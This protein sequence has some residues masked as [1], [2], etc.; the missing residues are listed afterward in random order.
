MQSPRK[1]YCEW[2]GKVVSL[3]GWAGWQSS[4]THGLV[5]VDA[6]DLRLEELLVGLEPGGPGPSYEVTKAI[7]P[8][9]I[10]CVGLKVAGFSRTEM[11]EIL[12][13]SESWVTTTLKRPELQELLEEKALELV[14]SSV[15]DARQAVQHF[16]ME[17]V[18]TQVKI[19][20]RAKDSVALAASNSLLD[21]GGVPRATV[22]AETKLL[23]DQQGVSDIRAAL[24]DLQKIQPELAEVKDTHK[25]LT[26]AKRDAAA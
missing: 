19:M 10:R 9:A 22:S 8:I 16:A 7:D 13:R 18:M 15:S 17:A 12:G 11:A 20:R 23:L 3:R 5:T 2:L 14:A 21:R 4:L 26:E 25:L 6:F 1:G 24:E